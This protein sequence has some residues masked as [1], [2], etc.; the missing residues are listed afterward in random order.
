MHVVSN[1]R[2][3]RVTMTAGAHSQS[4]RP[5]T[6]PAL[7]ADETAFREWYDLVLPRVYRFLLARCA[8]DV[9]LAEELTQQ[10]FIEAIRRRDQYDGR[11]DVVTWLCAIG[12]NKLVD[13]HRR[14]GRER[15]RQQRLVSVWTD[16][17]GDSSAGLD[18]RDAIKAALAE[19]TAEHRLVLVLRHLDE[20][21]VNEIARLIGRSYRATDSLLFRARDAFRRAYRGQTDG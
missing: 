10:T 6:L 12:R 8:G 3:G 19:L 18:E 7:V 5:T 16:V 1:G 4:D 13:H 21:P 20:L 17:E 15:R 9:A 2:E 14:L 11:A